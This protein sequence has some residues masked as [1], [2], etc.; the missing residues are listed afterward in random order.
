MFMTMKLTDSVA[1]R[2]LAT[3]AAD[4]DREYYQREIA[5]L[6]GVSAGATSQRLRDIANQGLVDAR[7]SG[8]MIFYRYNLDDPVARQFKILLNTNSLHDLI[9]D[10]A[11]HSRRIIL[12]GS[13]AEGSDGKASDIDLLIVSQEGETVRR[14]I[15]AHA[16]GI[17][18]KISP[19]VMS[20]NQF[21]HL[22]SKDRALYDGI[23]AG[24]TLWEAK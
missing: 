13:C 15:G 1:M 4:P 9:R 12:F 5:R 18:R 20:A 6:A 3:L 14:I 23:H 22:R 10:L 21:R 8:R 7:K 17:G 11:E 19:L 16:D 2:I 24:I